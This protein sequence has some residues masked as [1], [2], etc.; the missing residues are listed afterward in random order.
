MDS[1]SYLKFIAAL[2][3][4][5]A[6]I[7]GLTWVARR[8]GLI[9]RVTITGKNT[10]KRLNIVEVLTV[11]ARRR[12]ILI[13]RDDTEHL[14]LLGAE[15]DTLIESGIK[16]GLKQKPDIKQKKDTPLKEPQS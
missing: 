12:L 8:F 1:I 3:F 13:R 11:D 2:L 7:G 9:A 16:P 10:P 5:L 4:V 15:N 6:L 14:L